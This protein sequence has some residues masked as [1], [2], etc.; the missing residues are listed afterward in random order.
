MSPPSVADPEIDWIKKMMDECED[1]FYESF[2]VYDGKTPCMHLF[3][4]FLFICSR[5]LYSYPFDVTILPILF[6]PQM[7]TIC[8]MTRR[9]LQTGQNASEESTLQRSTLMLRDRALHLL[10]GRKVKVNMS[11]R[12]RSRATRRCLTGC[13]ENMRNICLEQHAKRRR[14]ARPRSDVMRRDVQRLSIVAPQPKVQSW[15]TATSPGLRRE[16]QCKRCWRWCYTAWIARTCQRSVNCW[17]SNKPCG[18]LTSLPSGVELDWRRRTSKGSWI[19]SR[20]CHKPSMVLPRVWGVS[21]FMNLFILVFTAVSCFFWTR[22]RKWILKKTL[23][24]QFG[25]LWFH[26]VDL[27]DCWSSTCENIQ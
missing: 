15:A 6:V 25:L 13:K 2:G 1:E 18:I 17:R 5:F 24:T 26:L 23:F 21:K 4:L 27:R 14:P 8:L 10:G 7:M 16:A 22:E 20:R 9:T 11:E 3:S 19:Q 12:R